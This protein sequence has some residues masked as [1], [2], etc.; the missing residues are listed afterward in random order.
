MT[1]GLRCLPRLPLTN[2]SNVRYYITIERV[3]MAHPKFK[4][5]VP[6]TP[7]WRALRREE[8]QVRGKIRHWDGEERLA[9]GPLPNPDLDRSIHNLTTLITERE[10]KAFMRSKPRH[11]SKSLW[12]RNAICEFLESRR[13]K[14]APTM[15]FHCHVNMTSEPD[16]REARTGS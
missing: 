5:L 16:P 2:L 11:V 12:V 3:I 4:Y 8:Q 15:P 1:L 6:H 7:A 14:T 10:F 13:V 9:P